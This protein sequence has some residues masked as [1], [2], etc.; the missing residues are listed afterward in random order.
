MTVTAGD[1]AA[2]PVWTERVGPLFAVEAGPATGRAIVFL[3]GFT[4]TG[5]SWRHVAERFVHRGFRVVLVDLPGHGGSGT[6]RADLSRTA[7]LVAATCGR[8]SYVGYSLGGRVGLHV[9]LSTDDVVER[10]ALIGAHPGIVDAAQ[11]AERRA[12]DAALVDRLRADGLDAFLE[13]WVR[14]PLFGTLAPSP[15][16]LAD[17][18]R[19]TVDGLAGSLALAGTGAQEPLWSRLGSLTMPVLAMAGADDTKF[20]E[21][22]ARLA[23]AVPNGRC[24][25]IRDAAHAAHLEQPDEVEHLLAEFVGSA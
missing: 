17:R 10:L 12:S 2:D 14:Q 15:A 3:H 19:N 5:S 4:Q 24:A 8:A 6:I 1:T 13:S 7:E 22:A 16:D 21:I 9:A 25:L 20:A 23:A 11:R 18:R